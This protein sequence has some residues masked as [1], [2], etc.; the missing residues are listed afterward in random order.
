MDKNVLKQL[1]Y[2]MYA[3]STLD[4]G[5][6]V[7]CIANSVMQVTYDTVVVSLN[8]NN[9]TNECLNRSQKFAVSILGEDIDNDIIASL[10]FQSGR[11]SDK[12]KG[13]EC[14]KIDE[15]CVIKSAIGYLICDVV[16]KFETDTH[17]VFVATI[18]SGEILRSDVLPM[19]YAYYQ[20]ERRGKSPQNAPTFIE[21]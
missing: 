9:Y 20:K 6:D 17:T 18:V 10:G 2:G 12:F 7:G 11:D 21:N 4:N 15:L 19:T 1:S 5:R 13:I 14:L 16:D 8:H 3:I